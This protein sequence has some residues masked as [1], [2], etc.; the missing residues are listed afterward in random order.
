MRRSALAL[1]AASVA[2]ALAPFPPFSA[3]ASCAAPYLKGTEDLVLQPGTEV[4]IQ[5]RAFVHGCQDSMGCEEGFGCDDDDC[6]YDGPEVEPME[7]VVLRLV[8]RGHTWQLDVAD[9][10]VADDNQ[11]GWVT[12]TFTVPADVEAGPAKLVADESGP[13]RIRVQR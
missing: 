9:S 10:G 5:G 12:W 8:Q 2:V 1:V 13:V 6:E 7:D 4:T 3:S 11:L